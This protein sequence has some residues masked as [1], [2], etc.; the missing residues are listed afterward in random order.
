MTNNPSFSVI[1]LA[2]PEI[3]SYA[4][5]TSQNWAHYC[6]RHGYSYERKQERMY[7][8][9]H[10][11]WSKVGYMLQALQQCRSDWV[12]VVDADTLVQTQSYRLETLVKRYGDNNQVHCLISEDCSRRL[13]VPLPLSLK[14]MRF[15]KTFRGA[16]SGF[17]GFRT[18]QMG[19]K[20][21]EDWLAL[22]R[23]TFTRFRVEAPH[24][25]AVF[26]LGIMRSYRQNVRVIGGE[27]MR[28][29]GN[30][31]LDWL[32]TDTSSAFVLHDKGIK[33]RCAA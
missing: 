20:I 23:T 3:D 33:Q 21:A 26:W 28:V 4:N 13:G 5:H 18:T 15:S 27:V 25:Q 17:F 1:M 22:G 32:L 6:E 9:M 11:Y 8:D 24:E 31:F 19:L 14:T 29:G 10:I 30:P 16:N 7:D 12:F 2:T